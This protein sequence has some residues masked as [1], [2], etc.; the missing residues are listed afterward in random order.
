M[1]FQPLFNG[2][3]VK[4]LITRVNDRRSPLRWLRAVTAF[5]VVAGLLPLASAQSVTVVEYYNRTLDAFFMTGRSNEK[6]L[7]DGLS[8]DFS[9]T[10]MQ[11][12]ATAA[13]T[14]TPSQVRV[15]RFYIGIASP[16]VSSHFY[17]SE[18]ID[19]EGLRAQNL[20]GFS[21][22][23]FDFAVAEPDAQGACAAGTPVPVYRSFRALANGRTSNH[24]YTTSQASY[25]ALTAAGWAPERVAFC[26]ATATD[27]TLAPDASFKRVVSPP[28]SPFAPGCNV[29]ASGTVYI[30]A[31]V[32]PHLATNPVNSRHMVAAWQQD[33]WSTGAAQGLA[34]AASFDGGQSWTNT[35]AAFSRCSGGSAA[36]GTNYERAS[37]PWLSIGPDGTAFQMALAVTGTSFTQSSISAMLMARSADGGRT[38]SAPQTLVRDASASIFHDKNTVKADPKRAAFVYAVWGRLEASGHGPAWFTRSTDGGLSW[39]S[40]RGIYDPGGT[41]QTLGNA[42]DVLPDGTVINVFL[43][44]IRRATPGN[45]VGQRVRIIRSTDNG[46]TWSPPF[47][48]SEYLGVG[49]VDPD[50]LVK[51]RDS[52]GVPQVAVGRDGR[53][54]VVWQ[55]SRFSGGAY[56]GVAYSQSTDGGITWSEAVRVNARSDVA[57]FVPGVHVRGDGTIGVS[58]YDFREN[59]LSPSTLPTVYRL[60]VS[61]DGVNWRESEINP[62]FNLNTA[63]FANGIFLGDYQALASNGS[64]FSALYA[65]TTGRAA[66]DT[67]EIVFANLADGSLKRSAAGYRA[68]PAPRDFVVTPELGDLVRQNIERTIAARREKYRQF[69]Q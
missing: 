35:L 53:I 24:R 27:A 61:T 32:E 16:L 69:T 51:V 60:A 12:T 54:H 29:Q 67:T 11:F 57:A 31:E 17:G 20:P 7:L 28:V 63:P 39:E 8:A 26:V 2:N 43:D 48:V 22:E 25:D 18:G 1:G 49:T 13:A 10:G 52:S 42:L 41:N 30:G 5:A 19:C 38:W 55:D 4:K 45:A 62:A 46:A 14:A 6:A 59:T 47:T 64:A 9:R 15:C 21:Y 44:I 68:S 36:S 65:R 23:G 40:S 3:F 50:T 33:R 58:Y 66:G 37:D 56:D 34:G